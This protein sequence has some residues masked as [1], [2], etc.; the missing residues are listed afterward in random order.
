MVWLAFGEDL[1]MFSIVCCILE[2]NSE[3]TKNEI[4]FLLK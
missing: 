1:Y 4:V 3:Q 2:N